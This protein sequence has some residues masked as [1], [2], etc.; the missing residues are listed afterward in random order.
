M[1]FSALI[2]LRVEMMAHQS[3]WVK[4][5][6]WNGPKCLSSLDL[7]GNLLF[8][9]F[10][11]AQNF[12]FILMLLL[13]FLLFP[14]SNLFIESSALSS[15][16]NNSSLSIELNDSFGSWVLYV[17]FPASLQNAFALFK[18]HVDKNLFQ[19]R[20]VQGYLEGYVASFLMEGHLYFR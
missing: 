4:G 6:V 18:D 12:G 1:R 13:H 19:L 8:H 15:V 14:H 20:L 16:I 3:I 17:Q 7:I 9:L 10:F 11:L 5:V 2:T